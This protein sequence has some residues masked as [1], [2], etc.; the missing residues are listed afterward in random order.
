MDNLPQQPA[1]NDLFPARLSRFWRLLD[2]MLI[3][4]GVGFLLFSGLILV[5]ALFDIPL[6][7]AG[8]EIALTIP[9][10]LSLV[11]VNALAFGLPAGAVLWIKRRS[12]KGFRFGWSWPSSIW[13]GRATGWGVA[14]IFLTNLV[15]GLVFWLRDIEP[16]N[17]QLDFI[18]PEGFT[19]L[20]AIGMT[21][22]VGLLVPLAE[23]MLFRG[24]I[25]R[26]LRQVMSFWP[27]VIISSGLF[28]L[29]HVEP[30]IAAGAALLGGICAWVYERSESIWTAVLIHAINNG[31]KVITLY[32]LLAFDLPI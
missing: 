6:S 30:A 11:A 5:Y 12:G 2:L 20:G 26:A 8:G 22:G 4:L 32:V 17:P 7:Q 31:S 3:G 10:S 28:G 14:T 16:E 29:F 19:W 18:L 13:I 15:A 1:A 27:A 25:H 21:V 24:V 23:E 9:L